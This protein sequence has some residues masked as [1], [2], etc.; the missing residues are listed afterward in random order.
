M[1]G[2]RE[3]EKERERLRLPICRIWVLPWW[4]NS[5]NLVQGLMSAV[6]CLQKSARW[7]APLPALLAWWSA[8]SKFGDKFPEHVGV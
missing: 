5:T 8:R 6:M 3:R 1:T 2:E 4:R 7:N